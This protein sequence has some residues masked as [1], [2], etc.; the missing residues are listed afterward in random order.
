MKIQLISDYR[1]YYDDW[2]DY[3][4]HS[5]DVPKGIS[6]MKRWAGNSADTAGPSRQTQFTILKGKLKEKTIPYGSV[7][8]MRERFPGK[9]LVVYTEG[10][11]HAGQGK[12]YYQAD[13][14]FKIDQTLLASLFIKTHPKSAVSYKYLQIGIDAFRL[15]V[16]S[17]ND[18]RTNCGAAEVEVLSHFPAE[19]NIDY[20][21]V[22]AIDYVEDLVTGEEYAIDLN[23]APGCR[24][25]GVREFLPAKPAVDSIS[26]WFNLYGPQRNVYLTLPNAGKGI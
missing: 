14:L 5:T 11:R 9:S 23:H 26:R 12:F 7:K 13:E 17:H 22:Y 25:L 3:Y 16:V 1:D 19:K 8:I 18:W 15:K 4:Q 10:W 20:Y 6:V 2:F 24:N 21:P